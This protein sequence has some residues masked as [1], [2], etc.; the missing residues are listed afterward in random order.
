MRYRI[1]TDSLGDK[2]IPAEAYYGIGSLR[3]KDIFQITKHGLHRQM[4]KAFAT[5][6]KS[7]AKANYDVGLISKDISN[8]I[9]LSCDEIL[10]GRLHGQFIT[11]VLQGG[12]GFS[13]NKN[14]NEVIANRA[15][16]MLGGDKGTYD[17]VHP[18]LHVNLNQSNFEVVLIA[19]KLSTVRL[20]KKLLVE[21]KKLH[22]AYFDLIS[23]YD[24]SKDEIFSI[25]QEIAAFSN[26]L[27]RDLER[28]DEAN[29][30]LLEISVG[31]EKAHIE[32]N[33][34]PNYIK[35]FIKYLAQFSG[36]NVYITKNII[37]NNRNLD[38]FSWLSS[39]F[40][41]MSLNLS[42][43]ANDLVLMEKQGKIII[44]K[45]EVYE[46]DVVIEM[47]KQ[48]SFYIMGNDLTI[49]RSV[50]AGELEKNIFLPIIFACLFE[51]INILR[52]TIRILR[53]HVIEH[54]DIK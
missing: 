29:D 50:E 12:S 22:N 37:D 52:R 31:L 24:L 13:M 39:A 16:E 14:A 1:E 48:V 20:T 27:D 46:G 2:Q 21:G 11:D 18:D 43:V 51:S 5:I 49:A 25:G 42:K 26:I 54:L 32:K 30:N 8:A 47:I 38:Y 40:K 41:S 23:N 53:E 33:P 6:K 28:I 17:K 45:I 9:A 44:P 3:S 4:I 35:K 19:G 36:D 7:A 34:D 15:N 10:N